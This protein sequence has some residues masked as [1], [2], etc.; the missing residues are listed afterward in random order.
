MSSAPKITLYSTSICTTKKLASDIETLRRILARHGKPYEEVDLAETPSRRADMLLA[1][2][3]RT[4][5]PQLHIETEDRTRILSA[6]E[7]QARKR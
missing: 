6:D 4:T 7:T 3:H 2:G 5:L 1:S